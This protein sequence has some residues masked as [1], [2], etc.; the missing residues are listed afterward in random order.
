M[1]ITTFISACSYERVEQKLHSSKS[2]YMT[3]FLIQ[4]T[5]SFAL[6]FTFTKDKA[7]KCLLVLL[8]PIDR[9]KILCMRCGQIFFYTRENLKLLC[10]EFFSDV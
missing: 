2:L 7:F 8:F 6:F 4:H 1:D 5:G 10:K 9:L 3:R